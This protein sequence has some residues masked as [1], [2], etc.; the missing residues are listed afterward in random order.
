MKN[1]LQNTESSSIDI[2][3]CIGSNSPCWTI[4]NVFLVLAVTHDGLDILEEHFNFETVEFVDPMFMLTC[5]CGP[6]HKCLA[7]M[8]SAT[9]DA[10]LACKE[11]N[12]KRFQK[13]IIAQFK[14]H[15]QCHFV[16]MFMKTLVKHHHE[17]STT[18]AD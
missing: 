15:M 2:S 16:F 12:W 9:N 10:Q 6:V 17:D 14:A 3:N 7:K 8:T 13:G 5:I 1:V 18:N 11:E 4:W